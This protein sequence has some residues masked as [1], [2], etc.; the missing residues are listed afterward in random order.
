MKQLK[1]DAK[2]FFEDKKKGK[3]VVDLTPSSLTQED[4]MFLKSIF[5]DNDIKGRTNFNLVF[6]SYFQ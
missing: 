4:I 2:K 1:T 3:V 5:T 6:I